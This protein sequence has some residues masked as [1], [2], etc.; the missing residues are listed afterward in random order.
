MTM[1]TPNI[2]NNAFWEYSVSRYTKGDMAPLALLLQDNHN[3]NVN[4]LLLICWCLE[5]N[6]II[7]LPQ[8]K[9][10]VGASA[11]TE[12]AL[13]SHRA[14]RKAA[15]PEK[16]GD[17]ATYDALKAQ[18]LDIERQQQRDIVASFNEQSVT[19]LGQTEA[20]STNVFN[21]SIAAFINAYGLR[22][23]SEARRLISLVINQL[24]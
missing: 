5:N 14:K 10:V 19:R 16:G 9:A 7:N 6:V 20:L 4:V 17:K 11:L 12:R 22:E 13:Q 18:E 3:V 2:E 15:S 21:A 1:P 23:N 24:S 8:L